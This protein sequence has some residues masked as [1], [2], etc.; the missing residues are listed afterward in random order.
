MIIVLDN[1]EL[2]L[3]D[4]EDFSR[5]S[6]LCRGTDRPSPGPGPGTIELESEKVAW[7]PISTVVELRGAQAS[8]SW[9]SQLDAMVEKARP[10]GWIDDA[11]QRIR[12]HIE[13]DD[14]AKS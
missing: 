10:Y 3:A 1:G 9:M 2:S 6:L 4:G 8:P 5:F 13:I 14:P 7:I 11:G 12:A